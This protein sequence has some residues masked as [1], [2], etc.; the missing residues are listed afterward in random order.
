M[1]QRTR[2]ASIALSMAFCALGASCLAHRSGTDQSV[3][4][5]SLSS[6]R[7]FDGNEWTLENLNVNAAQSYCYDGADANCRHYGRLYTW[8]AAGL[9]CRS[10]G[11]GWRLP[12]DH[13]WRRL[14][15]RYGGIDDES[16]DSGRMAYQEL[17]IGGPSGFNA[18][19]GGGRD[20]RQYARAD[21]HGFY[22]TATEND[23][24]N[25]V[26]Y[27]FA[28][29]GL[30]LHRQ[31][32]GEKWRALSVRCIRTAQQVSTLRLSNAVTLDLVAL[33]GSPTL[34]VGR[35]PVTMAQFRA[36][37]D[38]THYRTDAENPAGNGP[39]RVGG[40]GW[41]ADRKSF[42]GWFPRYTWRYL[43]WPLTD[44]ASGLQHLVE[45][46]DEVLRMARCQV[47]TG[48]AAADRAGMG[49]RHSRRHHH[50]ILFG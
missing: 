11:A 5:V 48:S 22:W 13:E 3:R 2:V 23:S 49:A 4:P 25:A 34:W 47:G 50:R 43:G 40:H 1:A 15:K 28:R 9:G 32:G 18:V 46:R 6:R 42:E 41:N 16:A 10:L 20:E 26:F 37:V 36:F 45:R 39:G 19:L 29:G 44:R 21:A 12:T 38:E 8:E 35:T 30:A 27:N 7:M 31:T 33:P 14:T 17:L 24:A